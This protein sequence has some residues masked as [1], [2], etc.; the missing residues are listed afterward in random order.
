MKPSASF[1]LFPL[2]LLLA[3]ARPPV[4]AELTLAPGEPLDEARVRGLIE[5]RLDARFTDS[6]FAIEI[7]RPLLPLANAATVPTAIDVVDWRHDPRSGRF[8]A[9][10]L[11]RLESGPQSRITVVGRAQELVPVPVPRQALAR[12]T[13]LTAELLEEAWL[14]VSRLREDTVL[15]GED[16]IGRELR[17]S[18]RRGQP[19]RRGQVRWPRLVE[20]GDVVTLV[21]D[22]PGL[23]L[24]ALGRALEAGSRG[25][26]IRLVNLD[27]ERPLRGRVT[28][29][30]RVEIIASE[31]R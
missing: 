9:R 1:F 3:I 6:R 17:R 10:L 28:G 23:L 27:S 29:P 21:F 31:A 19:V 7:F 16:L 26:I 24:T 2:L 13:I 22:R 25:Q 14:P 20:R 30:R 12:G 4:A 18:L 5:P 8:E 15:S 11:A